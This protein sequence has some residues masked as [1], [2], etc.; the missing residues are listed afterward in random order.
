M[1]TYQGNE[2]YIFISYAH[3]DRACVL[4]LIEGMQ[5]RGYRVWF[6][7]G[8]Q[9]GTDWT[10]TLG[11]KL[12]KCH[13]VIAFLSE[14]AVNSDYCRKEIT[15][16]LGCKKPLL[17]VFLEDFAL[18]SDMQFRLCDLQYMFAFRYPDTAAFLDTLCGLEVL[19]PCRSIQHAEGLLGEARRLFAQLMFDEA[20]DLLTQAAEA[21]CAEA[22]FELAERYHY[23][24]NCP[25]DLK[26]ATDWYHRAAQNGHNTA[27]FELGMCYFTGEG[28]PKDEKLAFFWMRQ[29]DQ[30]LFAQNIF[31]Y[32]L[33]FDMNGNTAE[34]VRLLA[35]A[36]EAGHAVAQYML[37]ARYLDGDGVEADRETAVAWLQK[38]AAQGDAEAIKLL[39]QLGEPC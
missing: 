37:G 30:P 7:A 15:F 5:A 32:A 17:P 23:G 31:T 10:A 33:V 3:A 6:D 38:A 24:E 21:E 11:E 1:H 13:C 19:A 29:G 26:A 9:G 34:A 16:A 4:P 8:I 27:Q 14:A 20:F 39:E 25:I 22:Q 18:P 12:E 2:P 35:V 36:A 28:V